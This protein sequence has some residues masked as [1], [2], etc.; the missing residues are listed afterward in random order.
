M[1][2]MT[3][4]EKYDK[5]ERFGYIKKFY[6]A[7]SLFKISL[8]TPIMAGVRTRNKQFS[9]CVLIIILFN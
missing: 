3:L 6:D 2:S 8:P 4:F 5:K 7:I 1:I 9:S